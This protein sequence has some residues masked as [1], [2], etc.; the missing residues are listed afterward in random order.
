[1]ATKKE[2]DD[3][4]KILALV[5]A[6]TDATGIL[7]KKVDVNAERMNDLEISMSTLAGNQTRL[8]EES[9]HWRQSFRGRLEGFETSNGSTPQ[10]KG[11]KTGAGETV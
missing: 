5:E 6:A 4:E 11:V 10:T 8:E 7:I 9:R 1:M 3:I 2:K